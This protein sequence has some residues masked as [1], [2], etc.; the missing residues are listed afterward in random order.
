MKKN[1]LWLESI[2]YKDETV[3]KKDICCDVLIIGGGITGIST[4]YQ[5]RNKQLKVVVVDQNKFGH[6]ITART[7]AKLTYLQE[8]IYSDL[9]KTYSKDCANKY[10]ESQR[11]AIDLVDKIIKE[12]NIKCD[13]KKVDS[14]VFTNKESELKNLENEKKLLQEFGCTVES[15][16]DREYS[17]INVKDTYVFHPLKYIFKLKDI[18]K[19]D[20]IEFYQNTNINYLDK[21]DDGYVCGNELFHIKAKK[22]VFACHYPYFLF[23]FLMPLKCTLEKSYVCASEV[24]NSKA[25]SAITSNKPTLSIRFHQDKKVHYRILVTDS[26]DLYKEY[27]DSMH[28]KH[29]KE[30]NSK[31]DG[32]LQYLWSNHDIM[33]FDKLPFIGRLQKDNKDLFLAT[34]YNTWGMT[35]GSLAGKMIADMILDKSNSYEDLFTPLR[36]LHI[37]TIPKAIYGGAK[38]M[39]ENKVWKNKEWYPESVRFEERKGEN[40]AIY[41]DK[42]QKEHI[43]YN[44]CP[45]MKCSL[46]FNTVEKTWDCPCHGSRFDLDGNVITG[47][48]NYSIKYFE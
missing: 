12:H 1:S 18:C 14:Y 37:K 9:E 35:N 42:F 8:L 39:I 28:F 27:N 10:Y 48:S 46:I 36:R 43:V 11:E 4:A 25:Y 47:P 5:L 2:K 22:V 41:V 45:H 3:L 40:V 29:L 19:E 6:A 13:L 38:P 32:H 7:T 15:G 33:T 21:C 23:P 26:H 31:L 16:N 34:G 24:E 17:F 20:G 30:V 44:K